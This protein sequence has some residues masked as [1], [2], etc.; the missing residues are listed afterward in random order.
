MTDSRANQARHPIFVG[1]GGDSGTGKTTV[2]AAFHELFGND[3][4]TSICLDDY[5]SLDRAQRKLV[6][7]TALNPRANN[8]ALMEED[9]W[10]LKRGEPIDKP[11]YDH[12]DGTLRGPEHVEPSEVVIVQGLHPFLVTGIRHTFDLKV[13]LGPAPELRLRWKV[14]RD[15]ARRGYTEEQVLA[16][17]E[18]RR[19]D[20]EAFIQPQ[21]RFADMVV[22]FFPPDGAADMGHLSVRIIQRHT[23]PR[24]A[25]DQQ[26]HATDSVRLALGVRDLDGE[27]ADVIEIDGRISSGDARL[28]EDNI[29]AHV[30]GRHGHVH[31]VTPERLGNYDAARER[32]HSD[33]LALTQLILAHRILSAQKSIVMRVSVADHEEFAGEHR[34]M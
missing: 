8:F 18:A 32:E 17:L 3:R 19:P 15:V 30:D 29:W 7:L 33:P 14:Q 26:L 23:M 16:E 21:R 12:H 20:A 28:V 34:H 11:I 9:L 1:I 4:I 10:A 24:I 2:A 31:H 25:F 6:G 5:H 27:P 22:N 13:W